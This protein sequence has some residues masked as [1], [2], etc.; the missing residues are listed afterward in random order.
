MS[1]L[2]NGATPVSA[3]SG[4]VAAATATATIPAVPG[5]TAYISGFHLTG[6]GATSALAVAPTVTGVVTGTLT[7]AWAAVA[8]AT[9]LNQPMI[10]LFDPPLSAS[11]VATAIAVSCPT[12]GS[13]NT[14]C[15]VVAYGY[16]L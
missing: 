1:H 4:T 16:Y 8:G 14:N 12:L 11:A 10:V 2:P 9:L 3:A 6:T 7:Y 15:A 13:G 5:R